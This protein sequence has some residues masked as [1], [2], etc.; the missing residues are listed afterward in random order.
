MKRVF[1]FL[2]LAI[3]LLL[4]ACNQEVI[5]VVQEE[6]N[7]AMPQSFVVPI[8]DALAELDAVLSMI[9]GTAQNGFRSSKKRTIQSVEVFNGGKQGALRSASE[10]P[11]LY[12]VNF[13]NEEGYAILAADDR[14]SS[15]V[16]AVVETGSVSLNDFEAD[17]Y[18]A[19]DSSINYGYEELENFSLYNAE[20]D[21]YY[22]ASTESSV[23]PTFQYMMRYADSE[24]G[25]YGTSGSIETRTEIGEWME[26][27]KVEPMVTTIW[28]Q[29]S[30]FNDRCPLKRWL[31]WQDYKRAPAG[32][33]AIAVSQI[34]AY[35]GYPYDL[36]CN[37]LPIIWQ[38]V[39]N[40]YK[41]GA[42]GS[43]TFAENVIVA[44]LVYHIGMQCS[45]LYTPDWSFALPRKAR[46]CMS[47]FGYPNVVRHSDYGDSR[48]I[49]M[50]D[51]GSPVFVA[52][53]SGL[54]SG[55]AWVVD[56]YI[57]RNRIDKIINTSTG[58]VVQDVKKEEFW[59][60]CNWGWENLCN[61]YYVSGVFNTKKGA[62]ATELYDS[63]ATGKNNFNWSFYTITYGN[64][65]Q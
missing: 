57:E 48:V 30:P 11:L 14:I 22:V 38:S 29:G 28:R 61:G 12:L 6:E 15:S 31:P 1:G 58:T 54:V 33:V 5:E 59:V 20:F 41:R 16:L 42:P 9:D 65:R 40:V 37:D 43:G 44:E 34:M 26:V 4:T 35:H 47:W 51:E 7:A 55:H 25:N 10:D 53:I 21:D 13:E 49:N 46:D 50:L 27:K 24:I 64:P 36:T 32:C 63:N 2:S 52:A 62:V 3:V 39:R 60:H 23:N 19:Y 45:T 8:E 18:D 56:G 17:D